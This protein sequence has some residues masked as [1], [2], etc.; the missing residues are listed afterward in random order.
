MLSQ[1]HYPTDLLPNH[2]LTVTCSQALTVG[3]RA[4]AAAVSALMCLCLPFC[5]LLNLCYL[6]AT[7]GPLLS[8]HYTL[9]ATHISSEMESKDRSL[10]KLILFF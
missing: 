2:P 1:E 8:S 6:Q 3:P 10:V 5:V 4:P 7:K 9:N